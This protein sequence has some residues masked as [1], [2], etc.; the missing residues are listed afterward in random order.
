MVR[1]TWRRLSAGRSRLSGGSP[2][3]S[4]VAFADAPTGSVSVLVKNGNEMAAL[5]GA[6]R[7]TN[8]QRTRVVRR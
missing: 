8:Q 3:L 7:V 2:L 1:V 5:T 4:G 6:L